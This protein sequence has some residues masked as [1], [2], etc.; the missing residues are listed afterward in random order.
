MSAI[1]YVSFVDIFFL[2]L[3]LRLNKYKWLFL[4]VAWKHLKKKK[5][6]KKKP[7]LKSK[8]LFYLFKRNNLIPSTCIFLETVSA[9]WP[10]KSQLDKLRIKAND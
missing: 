10:N 1:L 9:S 5:N 2:T 8:N 7:F 6:Q 4:C 3:K